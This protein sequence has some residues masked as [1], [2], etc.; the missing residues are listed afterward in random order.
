[1]A[2]LCVPTMLTLI[3][4]F[5]VFIVGGS[6]AII[7]CLWP[8]ISPEARLYTKCHNLSAS[9]R[10]DEMILKLQDQIP[11]HHT[12]WDK[13]GSVN[14]QY[15]PSLLSEI[16]NFMTEIEKQKSNKTHAVSENISLTLCLWKK[17]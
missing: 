14:Y 5:L 6:D 17:K 15:Y 13:H 4:V 3:P 11:V 9:K 8:K 10:F 2:N 7:S 12:H 16:N 1:M